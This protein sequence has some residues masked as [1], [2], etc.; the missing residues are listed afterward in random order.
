[1][2]VI[3]TNY[4]NIMLVTHQFDAAIKVVISEKIYP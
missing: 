3:S 2:L 1:M 4:R